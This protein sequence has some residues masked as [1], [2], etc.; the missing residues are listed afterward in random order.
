MKV[1][2]VKGADGVDLTSAAGHYWMHAY[3]FVSDH[4]YWTWTAA[5]GRWELGDVPPGEYELVVWLP[6][7][8]VAK[9]ERDPESGAVSRWTMAAGSEQGKRVVVGQSDLSVPDFVF[10]E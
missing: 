10:K 3:L 4:P 2:S 5:D 1:L 9:V 6:S 7:W 8:R